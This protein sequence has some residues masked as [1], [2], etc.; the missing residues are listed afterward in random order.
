MKVQLPSIAHK[1]EHHEVIETISTINPASLVVQECLT[2]RHQAIIY[3]KLSTIAQ[4]DMTS[5]I[6]D[7]PT[8]VTVSNAVQSPIRADIS[9]HL[10]RKIAT[11]ITE[12]VT[13]EPPRR[14]FFL[15]TALMYSA[16]H[17]IVAFFG[18]FSKIV[19]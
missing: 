19:N 14:R 7:Q 13:E 6:V 3:Y 5:E 2:T 9:D 4:F 12:N 18:K 11:M 8:M 1:V 16:Y 10:K 15:F 17:Q